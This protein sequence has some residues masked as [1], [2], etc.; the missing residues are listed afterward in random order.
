MHNVGRAG[1]RKRRE[2]ARELAKELLATQ[3]REV[4]K[5]RP[6]LLWGAVSL[7]LPFGWGFVNGSGLWYV[8]FGWFLWSIPVVIGLHLCWRWARDRGLYIWARLLTVG[9]FGIVFLLA[10]IYSVWTSTLPNFLYVKPGVVFNPVKPGMTVPQWEP[11]NAVW[12]FIVVN[13]GIEPFYNIHIGFQDLVMR[14]EN[15]R[16]LQ[17]EHLTEAE[18]HKLRWAD[19]DQHQYPELDPNPTSS[20]AD[21]E[22]ESFNW[23]PERPDDEHYGIVINYRNA[24][25]TEDLRIKKIGTKWQYAMKVSDGKARQLIAC[26]DP[27]FPESSEWPA[28]LSRC[29]PWYED[30][31]RNLGGR[32]KLLV[33]KMLGLEQPQQGISK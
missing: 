24:I 8:S 27:D 2:E 22:V 18:S 7:F 4:H 21:N 13:R 16:R 31:Y 30:R 1:R 28:T 26:K 20:G 17:N 12:M 14:E 15:L 33:R 10:A 11:A 29:F 3:G 19:V 5:Y 25:V 6:E 32:Y 9:V 23:R